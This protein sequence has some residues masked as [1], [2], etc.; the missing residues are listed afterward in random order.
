M[1]Q[2]WP[3][4]HGSRFTCPSRLAIPQTSGR[5]RSDG[6]NAKNCRPS[7][8]HSLCGSFVACDL[9]AA[10]GTGPAFTSPWSSPDSG[11]QACS[12]SQSG[13]TEACSQTGFQADDRCEAGPRPKTFR[14]KVIGECSD[15]IFK[16]CGEAVIE[17]GT[18]QFNS[19]CY[20]EV[21]RNEPAEISLFYFKSYSL[22]ADR[23][24]VPPSVDS[25]QFPKA[26][27]NSS[28]NADRF[29]QV[30]S[31]SSAS[32]GA[33]RPAVIHFTTRLIRRSS[34]QSPRCRSQAEA[35]SDSP[36]HTGTTATSASASSGSWS[37]QSPH[38]VPTFKGILAKSFQSLSEI[39][40]RPNLVR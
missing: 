12:R 15:S 17:F 21:I 18:D 28:A 38:R 5:G 9:S 20:K 4:R 10:V 22:N 6:R 31:D 36:C 16:A 29:E 32:P 37:S 2:G 35:G 7:F 13:L 8:D 19:A 11:P 30:E 23:K 27:G 24:P 34:V 1:P 25:E 39:V 14:T 26:A 40:L 33:N 3:L